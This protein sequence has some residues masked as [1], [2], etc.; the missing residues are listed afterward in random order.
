VLL[1]GAGTAGLASGEVEG[2]AEP[3]L[4]AAER[5]LDQ[6]GRVRKRCALSLTPRSV[7]AEGL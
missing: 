1:L 4:G 3:K 5:L 6:V 2:E 7:V